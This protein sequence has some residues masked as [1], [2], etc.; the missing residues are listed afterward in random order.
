MWPWHLHLIIFIY[1]SFYGTRYPES[2]RYL[3]FMDKYQWFFLENSI[4]VIFSCRTTRLI[5]YFFM[6]IQCVDSSRPLTRINNCYGFDALTPHI[7]KIHSKLWQDT[8]W[9]H[10]IITMSTTIVLE[11]TAKRH[12][13][14][15]GQSQN[16]G[17]FYIMIIKRHQNYNIPPVWALYFL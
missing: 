10:P 15:V 4:L 1:W 12:V 7:S 8:P 14:H 9:S 6:S 17:I 16:K 3:E 13:F 2:Q 11:R 5:L